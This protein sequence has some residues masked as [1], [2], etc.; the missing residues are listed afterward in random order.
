MSEVIEGNNLAA[1]ISNI[2]NLFLHKEARV[3]FWQSFD[4]LLT[5]AYDMI[6]NNSLIRS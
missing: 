2:A 5:S 1:L 6:Y 4:D 3:T